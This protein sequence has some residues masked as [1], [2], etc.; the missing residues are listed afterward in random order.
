MSTTN[1]GPTVDVAGPQSAEFGVLAQYIKDFS[2]ENPNA[3]RS[4]SPLQQQP[5]IGIQVNVTPK[6]L[7]NTD[8]EV[9]LRI[10]GKAEASGLLLFSFDLTFAGV[11][12]LHNIPPENVSP[13]I[14]IEAPRLLF[15]FAREIISSAISSGGFPPLLLNP[16]DFVALYQKKMAEMQPPVEPTP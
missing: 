15:P 8:F 2:F 13:L 3:P 9:E 5:E 14:M 4:L 1:G 12:R 16:V 10:D 6:A 7:S 11:F